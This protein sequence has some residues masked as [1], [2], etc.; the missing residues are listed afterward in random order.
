VGGACGTQKRNVVVVNPEGV[1]LEDLP[2]N[3]RI[4]LKW[5]LQR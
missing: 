1:H 5:N 4:I 3:R 2:L